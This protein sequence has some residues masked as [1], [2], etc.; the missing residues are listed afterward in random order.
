MLCLFGSLFVCLSSC[1]H[2]Y[3]GT[4]ASD[5]AESPVRGLDLGSARGQAVESWQSCHEVCRP[6]FGLAAVVMVTGV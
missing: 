1:P 6:N 5:H 2:A 4:I 3:D